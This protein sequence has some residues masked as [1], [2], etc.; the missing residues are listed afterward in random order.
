MEFWKEALE[1][2]PAPTWPPP[3][4]ETSK[5]TAMIHQHVPLPVRPTEFTLAVFAQAAFTLSFGSNAASDDVAFGMTFS[6]RDASL[7]S[8]LSTAGPTL[9]TIPFRTVIDRHISLFSFL[10]SIRQSILAR[11]QHGHIGLPSIRRA[12]PSAAQA[13]NFRCV[14]AVQPRRVEA[15]EEVFGPRLSFTE[16]MGRLDLI[17]EC[18]VTKEGVE[19]VAEFNCGSLEKGQVERVVGQFADLLPRL[20]ELPSETLVGDIGL[21]AEGAVV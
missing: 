16:E 19:V 11:S 7:P 3:S 10:D 4:P 1:G 12:S 18:F 17:F 8:I 9:Y 13:C 6:G 20:V 2:S 14:F 21:I 5:T 15:S